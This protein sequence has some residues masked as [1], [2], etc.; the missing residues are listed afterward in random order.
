MSA[1]WGPWTEH[2]G[3]G[4]PAP[5][6][7]VA[8]RVYASGREI[9]LPIGAAFLQN[10]A[11]HAY[12]GPRYATAWDWSVRGRQ[13]PVLR[14]RLRRPPALRLLVDLAETLPEPVREGVDA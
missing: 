8:H 4:W 13:I 14:Y 6:G 10:S 9:V 1:E 7:T 11:D 2:D 12:N 5:T 3:A